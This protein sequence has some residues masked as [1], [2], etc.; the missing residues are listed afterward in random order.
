MVT[1]HMSESQL[2][3]YDLSKDSSK[4]IPTGHQFCSEASGSTD[5]PWCGF[6]APPC[7]PEGINILVMLFCPAEMKGIMGVN[8]THLQLEIRSFYPFFFPITLGKLWE[9][10]GTI[11]KTL[12]ASRYPKLSQWKW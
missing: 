2:E 7:S 1:V 12:L 11:F 5:Q 3:S 6:C 10:E 9:R 8:V 4:A